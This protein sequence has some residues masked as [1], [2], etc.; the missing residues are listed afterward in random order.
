M[1]TVGDTKW[2]QW[3]GG[4]EEGRVRGE[5]LTIVFTVKVIRKKPR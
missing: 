2:V 4:G 5:G 3:C 1:F